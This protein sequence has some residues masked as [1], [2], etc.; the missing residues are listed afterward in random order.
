MSTDQIKQNELLG[1]DAKTTQSY[2]LG[3]TSIGIIM[4]LSDLWWQYWSEIKKA[5]LCYFGGVKY[6]GKQVL[7]LAFLIR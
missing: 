5:E 1:A 2:F 7:Y 6:V 3:S 4:Q